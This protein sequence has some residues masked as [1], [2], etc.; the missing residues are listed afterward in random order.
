[1]WKSGGYII[2]HHDMFQT[3]YG[4]EAIPSDGIPLPGFS[5]YHDAV[6]Y[7]LKNKERYLKNLR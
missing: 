2:Y 3:G 6:F 1:M 4:S 5:K 7:F